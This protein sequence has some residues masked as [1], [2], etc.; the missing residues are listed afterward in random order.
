M[1]LSEKNEGARLSV[2]TSEQTKTIIAGN[3]SFSNYD[4]VNLSFFVELMLCLGLWN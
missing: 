1:N 2:H 4:H 3:K